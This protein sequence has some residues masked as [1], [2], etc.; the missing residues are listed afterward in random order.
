MALK[1]T[2]TQA[3]LATYDADTPRRE[4]LWQDAKTDADVDAAERADAEA[5][6]RV[7]DAYWEDT[8]DINSRDHR[9]DINFMR[10]MAADGR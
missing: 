3:A 10:E 1:F 8:K 7:R 5:L 9:A 2:N 6:Q 4:A